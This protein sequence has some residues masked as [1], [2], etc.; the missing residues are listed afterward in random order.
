[1]TEGPTHLLVV[2]GEWLYV[3]RPRLQPQLQ[4]NQDDPMDQTTVRNL[5]ENCEELWG[6]LPDKPIEVDL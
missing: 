6:L 5:E 3:K 2:Y 4:F 1:M